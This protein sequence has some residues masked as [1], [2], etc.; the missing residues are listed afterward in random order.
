MVVDPG[1][2]RPQM[3]TST[4]RK[5]AAEK[6]EGLGDDLGLLPDTFI[7]PY[8][9]Q[10]PGLLSR[11][12]ARLRLEWLYWKQFA[13]NVVGASSTGGPKQEA[14]RVQL[15][16]D[17]NAV[18]FTRTLIYK[19]SAVKPRPKLG[20]L[21][22]SNTASS[23][24]TTMYE[25]LASG[26]V[27]ALRPH[28]TQSLLE[29]LRARIS[30]RAPGT[31]FRWK[32][33]KHLRRPR[34]VSFKAAPLSMS[35]PATART[36]IQQAVVRFRTLQS[37]TMVKHVKQKDGSI[38]E[39]NATENGQEVEPKE[40]VEYFVIQKF[41]IKGQDAKWVVWGTTEP[42]TLEKVEWENKRRLGLL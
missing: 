30:A 33:H 7:L 9:K 35:E 38:V 39:V 3:A 25:N 34:L 27:D 19:F 22:L 18:F 23:L 37:L 12:Q 29:T 21:R 6:G 13:W 40:I 2:R 4:A 1:K 32:L 20:I 14:G 8:G 41:S 16:D 26:K 17:T 31:T 10:L 42:M 24:Y 15:Q 28:L 36:T 5:A 11:P